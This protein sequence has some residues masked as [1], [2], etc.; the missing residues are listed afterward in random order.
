MLR[1][2]EQ[3]DVTMHANA[4]SQ[5]KECYEKNKAGD[6]E[7]RS[8]TTSMKARLRA[9]VGETYWKKAHDYLDHFLKQKGQAKRQAQE[10]MHQGG[11]QPQ[12]HHQQQQQ[13]QQPHPS[14]R[15][16]VPP[17]V[18]QPS[19]SRQSSHHHQQQQQQQQ[20]HMMTQAQAQAAAAKKVPIPSASRGGP[21]I[22]PSTI[23]VATVLTDEQK[24]K[25]EEEEKAEKRRKRNEQSK[26]NRERKKREKE[27]AAALAAATAAKEVSKGV[28]GLPTGVGITH[29]VT[30]A[31]PAGASP[32][33]SSTQS[34][35]SS[36]GKATS[37]TKAKD[38]KTATKTK[39]KKSTAL[40]RSSS[41]SSITKKKSSTTAREPPHKLMETI[42]HAT[43]IDVKGFPSL[44]NTQEYRMDVNLDE[45][46]R[47]L[48][49]G[50]EKQQAKVKD[51]TMAAS[52]ALD[53]AMDAESREAKFKEAG[54]PPLPTRIPS[55]YD[56]WGT[57]NV[58]SVRNAWAKVRLP[59]SE[60]QRAEK[61]KEEFDKAQAERP[62]DGLQVTK[63]PVLAERVLSSPPSGEQLS[64][65]VVAPAASVPT[66]ENDTTNHVWFNEARAE[67]DPTLA[68]LSEA[69]EVFL[70]TTIEK[71]ISKARL[72]QNL[73]GVR[74]WH[75]LQ[76][77][78]NI[79]NY[80]S[81]DEVPTPPA[82]IRL[83]CDVR[84]QIALA[85]GNAAKVY[86]RMEEAISRQNDTYHTNDSTTDPETM[87]L[88]STSMGDLSKKP[89]LKSAAEKAN[90]DAKRKFAVFV[91]SEIK[92]P[93]GSVPTQAKVTL[94]DIVVGELG[95]RTS[96]IAS[97]RKRFRVGLKY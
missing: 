36:K 38:K 83:G 72:R 42:D 34:S 59:E 2:L 53:T 54:V 56:G 13:H 48:L 50:D 14:H 35:A 8:L 11:G 95:N 22:P 87:L 21:T 64:S 33:V 58:V 10:Q 15:S 90:A 97:R 57:K 32:S 60:M 66:I 39:D 30:K 19:S 23:P 75:T 51:I 74:L 96:M 55:V 67:Q 1:Y 28:P 49:Y 84:R 73:D 18:P 44:F 31:L 20:Q 92:P 61:Q 71:A 24:K 85:E 76:A 52:A 17:I 82:F 93:L 78:S 5:I 37:G 80:A 9:T 63:P 3:R 47:I 89:P 79:P 81:S 68:L 29:T 27:A 4:K 43:L 77:H 94:Q 88:E 45:E 62:M 16:G 86:Q 40:K 70:K 69:T 6:P 26:R 46:Q 65:S 91:G 12:H 25:R 7:F 41:S